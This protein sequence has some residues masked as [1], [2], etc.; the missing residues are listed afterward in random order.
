MWFHDNPDVD[1]IRLLIAVL[2]F[3]AAFFI[4]SG[5][6]TFLKTWWRR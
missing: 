1:V 4:G 6:D 5:A 2:L 3:G